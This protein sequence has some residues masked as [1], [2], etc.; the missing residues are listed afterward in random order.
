MLNNML[1]KCSQET[2]ACIELLSTI[3]TYVIDDPHQTKNHQRV[4]AVFTQA[5]AIDHLHHLSSGM[6]PTF[7]RISIFDETLDKT[8]HLFGI[9][10]TN[11]HMNY[12]VSFRCLRKLWL[13]LVIDSPAGQ[14]QLILILPHQLSQFHRDGSPELIVNFI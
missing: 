2:T 10:G 12:E 14:Y 5:A 3:D 6:A 9:Q 11:I 1:Y 4:G 13:L 8:A 7:A